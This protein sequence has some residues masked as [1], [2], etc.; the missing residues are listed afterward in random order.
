MVHTECYDKHLIKTDLLTK[1][2]GIVVSAVHE[3]KEGML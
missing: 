2:V 1:S 3:A